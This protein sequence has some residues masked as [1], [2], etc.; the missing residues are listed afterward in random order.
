MAGPSQ[1]KGSEI[2]KGTVSTRET[3][4]KIKVCKMVPDCHHTELRSVLT[5][6]EIRKPVAQRRW[7][8][9][10]QAQQAVSVGVGRVSG[11]ASYSFSDSRTVGT[12]TSLVFRGF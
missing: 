3:Q 2:V 9:I 12:L 11:G 5:I 6:K 8:N 4:D 7:T 1:H 10:G